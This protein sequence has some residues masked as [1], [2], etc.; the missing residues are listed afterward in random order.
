MDVA[1]AVLEWAER[2]APGARVTGCTVRPLAGGSVAR[3]VE[4][5]TLHLSGGH[6][7]LELVR[8]EAPAL[9]VAGLGAAQA[10]RA[11]D[12]AI[13]ELV[14]YGSDWLILPLAP[15]APLDWGDPVP[16]NLFDSLAALHARYHGGAGLPAAIPRVTPAWWRTLCL[17][18]AAAARGHG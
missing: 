13:P 12:T 17:D 4:R 15:G 3:W 14:A 6:A 16:G 1:P 11:D 9:E 8:K 2:A 18:W 5:L 7:P 10:A